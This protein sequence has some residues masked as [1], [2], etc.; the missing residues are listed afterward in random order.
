M[1]VF[2]LVV[3]LSVIGIC[4]FGGPPS[5]AMLRLQAEQAEKAG[6]LAGAAIIADRVLARE[7]SDQEMILRAIR[8]AVK[9]DQPKAVAGYLAK[10]V[11]PDKDADRARALTDYDSTM[12]LAGEALFEA[13]YIDL[14]E[15][16]FR[17]CLR[18]SPTTLPPIHTRLAFLLS[19]E[20]RR[21]ESVP[22]LLEM[23]RHGQPT[24]DQLLWLSNLQAIVGDDS[25]L[26]TWATVDPDGLGPRLGIAIRKLA[27]RDLVEAA[28]RL[29]PL[30]TAHPECAEVGIQLGQA[31]LELS[32]L[33]DPT[34]EVQTLIRRTTAAFLQWHS[35]TGTDA[36]SHPDLW[37]L[38]GRWM[39]T[40]QDYSGAI[41]CFSEAIRRNPDQHFACYQLAQLLRRESQ[42]EVAQKCLLRVKQLDELFRVSN[43]LYDNRGHVELLRQAAELTESL[44]RLWEAW[45]WYRMILTVE[46]KAEWAWQ[47]STRLRKRLEAERPERVLPE[48]N[49]IVE[50]DLALYP[51]PD[52]HSLKDA[53]P[54]QSL[55]AAPDVAVIRFEDRSDEAGVDFTY[56]NSPNDGTGERSFEFTGG[57]IAVID[58]DVD[59]W[60]DLYFTQGCP[61][62]YQPGQRE[63][64]DRLYRNIDGERFEDL[65]AACGIVDDR[66][67]QG[68]TVGDFDSDGFPDLYVANIG[69][70]QFLRNNGDGT[71][72][73]VTTETGTAGDSWSTSCVLA[74]V[75]ADG[76][77]DLYVVNYLTGDD[78]FTRVCRDPDGSARL[79]YPQVFPSAADQFYL[80]RGDGAFE[81]STASRGVRDTTGR[82]LGIVAADF[83][84]DGR[85][86]FFVANDTT[87][88]Y[89]FRNTGSLWQKGA[90]PLRAGDFQGESAPLRRVSPLLPQAAGAGPGNL[91]F[92]EQGIPAGLAFGFSGQPQASMGVAVA[93]VD[94]D[95][96]LDLF[97]T[98]FEREHNNLY[99]Q[100]VAGLFIDSIEKS[101]MKDP[102]YLMLGF[103]TQFLD[104]D[105]DGWPDLIVA[106]GHIDDFTRHG[107]PYR[108]QPQFFRNRG[109][110]AFREVSAVDLGTYFQGKHLGR[111]VARLDWNRDGLED[112]TIGHLGSTSA[113]L[114]NRTVT[115][116]G[117]LVLDLRGVSSNRDAIG[118]RVTLQIGHET[119]HYQLMAGDGYQASNER[120]LVMGIGHANR[121]DQVI[122]SWPNGTRQSFE[123]LPTNSAWTAIEGRSQLVRQQVK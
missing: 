84:G 66:F 21:W 9:R 1:A 68:A 26:E 94:R 56:F 72:R 5:T 14:A 41:R 114:A 39:M 76:L 30:V 35:R 78:V 7:P 123:D 102:S 71:F 83:E 119:Q 109:R 80:N 110:G 116:G 96:R 92:S 37:V 59:G 112:L 97:V 90:D 10:C 60:P 86:S 75:N 77:P 29:V 33:D 23:L 103:G 65:T 43:L 111:A 118:A 3:I 67:S 15:A 36:D 6:D 117:F 113:L 58:F 98:N 47:N 11:E 32:Q 22:H 25:R 48:E 62:P 70:N 63:F 8:V 49:P 34:D 45:G 17:R 31:A 46:P 81:E 69:P 79:C 106:N 115:T 40:G 107:I 20:G 104:A 44:G 51:L 85:M 55:E 27:R 12:S 61:W 2:G 93:D 52:W 73:N 120:R 53:A 16:C 95:G 24:F 42:H 91:S 88:N 18:R 99:L 82:G 87:A 89:Y 28:Q 101:G 38:R 64:L 19:C 121:I 108:M 57:G 50:L 100:P 4:F 122:I 13:G 74:D 105:L 54:N